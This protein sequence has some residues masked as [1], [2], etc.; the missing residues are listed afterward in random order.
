M[1]LLV[2]EM[3]QQELGAARGEGRAAARQECP[4]QGCPWICVLSASPIPPP[5][6]V[7]GSQESYT[8]MEQLS[9]SA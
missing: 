3:L 6:A 9:A 5:E 8:A 4:V 7:Q 1:Q 2:L